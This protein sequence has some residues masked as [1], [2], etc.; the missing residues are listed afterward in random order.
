MLPTSSGLL[1][2]SSS[3]QRTTSP[4]RTISTKSLVEF[5]AKCLRMFSRVASGW[6]PPAP[7]EGWKFRNCQ[8]N[9]GCPIRGT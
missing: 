1:I 4:F 3:S 8:V 9:Q 5:E 6:T 7:A 2:G